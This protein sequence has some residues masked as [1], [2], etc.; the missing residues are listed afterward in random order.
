MSRLLIQF[1]HLF[2]SFGSFPLFEDVSLS[3]NEGELFAVIGEN[4]AGKTTLLQ[5]LAGTLQP[6]SGN[7]IKAANLSIG[8]L[9]QEIVLANP[10]VLVREFI[11]GDSLL[12]LEREMAACLEDP[13]RL[14][15]WA[16][17]HEKYE[18]LGGYR[19][20]P[21]EQVLRGLKLESSLLDLPMS[22]LSSGQRVRAALA[23]ALIENSDLLLLDEPTNHLDQE[24][25]D[26]LE[27]ALR[28]RKGQA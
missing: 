15:E 24:M 2:K 5:L 9:P 17:L 22:R 4:G 19:Q 27:A 13:S 20:V 12:D 3:I 10:S 7:L 1:S 18:Q 28:K 21:V 23:K 16:E 26:W 8:S 6:D 14:A 11:E 25:L